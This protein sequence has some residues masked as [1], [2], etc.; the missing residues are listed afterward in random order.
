MRSLPLLLAVASVVTTTPTRPLPAQTLRLDT[1]DATLD[2]SFSLVRGVRELADGRVLIAD[3]I[4][5]RVVLADLR[6]GS[7]RLLLREGSGPQE[8]RLPN[9]LVRHRA[10]S[11]LLLDQGN[12]RILLLAPDG[13]AV[14]AYNA[15][16]PGR[17]GVRGAD[18]TG[19][20][21]HV[22]P[23]WA[24]GPNALPDDSVRLVRWDP[25]RDAEPTTVATVQGTRWR[26]DQSPAREPRM[27][28]IGFAAQDGWAVASGGAI[29]IVRTAPYR[30]EVHARGRAPTIG[31]AYPVDLRPLRDD[32]K[33]RFVAEFNFGSPVSGRGENGGLGRGPAADAAQIRR[34]VASA[35]W[36]ERFPP[37]D[38]ARVI[39]AADGRLWVGAAVRPDE[40][41][42]YDVFDATGTRVQQ[43]QLRAGRRVVHVGARSVYAVHEDTDGVQ[44]VERYPLR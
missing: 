9:G 29:M 1:P 3:W 14:R 16:A 8:T 38:A 43:V 24:E 12:N 20:L 21:Y 30:V 35:E 6:S 31:P 26:K 34:Q 25:S 18:A 7:V 23:S 28:M 22:V 15:E 2:E 41:S 39:A 10:D 27:P 11:T 19:G 44:T 42:R 5:N 13:R 40:P 32:D 17:G 37:F 33:R 4:E 36:A